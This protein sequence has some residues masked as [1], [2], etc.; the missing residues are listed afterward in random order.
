MSHYKFRLGR[1][2]CIAIS[3]GYLDYPPAN[4]FANT[5]SER[6][7]GMLRERQLPTDYVRTPYTCLFVNTGTHRIMVD[8]GAG[9]LSP[10]TGRL[11]TNMQTAGIDPAGVD[12]IIITHAHPDHIGG[13][14]DAAGNPVCPNARYVISNAEWAFWMDGKPLPQA[15]QWFFDT[16][17]QN[18]DPVRDRITQVSGETELV[19]GITTLP[20]PGHTPGHMA[21]SIVS[22]G[23]QLLHVSDTVLYPLHLE[24]PEIVPVYDILPE[25]AAASKRDVFDRASDDNALVFA[26]H[27]PPFP[28]LGHVSRQGNG[29]Y[30]EPIVTEGR[31]ETAAAV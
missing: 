18:L 21:L 23:E 29:W 5:E 27:F 26:H 8:I 19:P 24:H 22:D 2:E 14:L 3:D 31:G 11:L 9:G 12:V 13:N 15:P 25:A 7:A 10:T 4:F 28:N 16:F 20:A 1:F 6:V 17:H 30:W